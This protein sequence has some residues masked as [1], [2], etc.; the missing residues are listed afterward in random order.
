MVRPTMSRVEGRPIAAL[1]G[2][3][4]A[5]VSCLLLTTTPQLV[6]RWAKQAGYVRTEVEFLS[7]GSR[8]AT[9]RVAVTGESLT[10]RRSTFD[11]IVPGGRSPVWYNPDARLVAGA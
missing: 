3:L 1:T 9:V 10:V 5:L 2:M 8:N 11:Q 6:Y 4:L 7:L